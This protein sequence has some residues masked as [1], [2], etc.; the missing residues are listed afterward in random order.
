MV[1]A[2]DDSVSTIEAWVP[3]LGGS[4][5]PESVELSDIF[6]SLID[7]LPGTLAI[8]PDFTA[9]FPGAAAWS[10]E[11]PLGAAREWAD[12]AVF[13]QHASSARRTLLSPDPSF[14]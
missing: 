3:V 12:T 8:R 6:Q 13:T 7:E 14:L 11:Q 1:F 5:L 2:N 10:V 4:D 9:V